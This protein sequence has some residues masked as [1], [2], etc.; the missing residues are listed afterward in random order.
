MQVRA[1]PVAKFKNFAPLTAVREFNGAGG[2]PLR[3]SAWG[4]GRVKT[5]ASQEAVAT[6]GACLFSKIEV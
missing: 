3:M 6:L 1:W 2:I 5:C 4:P